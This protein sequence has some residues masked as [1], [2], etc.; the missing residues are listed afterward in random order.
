VADEDRA[1][2]SYI[3]KT[4]RDD[5]HIVFHAYDVLSAVQLALELPICLANACRST[6]EVEASLPSGVL[7]IREPFAAAKFRAAVKAKRDGKADGPAIVI[8]GPEH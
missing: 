3:V 1:V 8:P 7:I 4:L 2:V 5:G 6:P